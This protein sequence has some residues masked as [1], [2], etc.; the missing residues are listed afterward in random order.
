MQ[1]KRSAAERN[2]DKCAISYH[3]SLSNFT[4]DRKSMFLSYLL[5]NQTDSDKIWYVCP[6]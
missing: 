1:E 2:S 3:V 6:A 4:V 5:Q